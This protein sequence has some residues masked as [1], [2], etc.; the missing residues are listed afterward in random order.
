MKK[1]NHHSEEAK[2]KMSQS[3]K[4]R[5]AKAPRIIKRHIHNGYIDLST[6]DHRIREHR[7]VMEEKIGRKL[8]SYEIVHH[9]NGD[10]FDNHPDNLVLMT[11][12]EHAG[13]HFSGVSLKF[14]EARNR[15]PQSPEIVEKRRQSN[16]GK[17]RSPGTRELIRQAAFRR[18]A[19]RRGEAV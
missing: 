16:L 12:A 4:I 1:G 15:K 10:R 3:Q 17:K 13:H 14:A 8:R 2:R 9:I 11:R 5:F 18:E 7:F 6:K 19:L